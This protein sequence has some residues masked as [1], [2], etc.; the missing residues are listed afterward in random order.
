V[1]LAVAALGCF[2]V[3]PRI[4]LIGLCY[5]EPRQFMRLQETLPIFL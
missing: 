2:H 4:G 3:S 1:R 5:E